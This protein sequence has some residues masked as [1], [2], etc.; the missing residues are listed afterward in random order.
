VPYQFHR[1]SYNDKED[2]LQSS[3]KV[4]NV[5]STKMTTWVILGKKQ[6]QSNKDTT[7]KLTTMPDTAIPLVGTRVPAMLGVCSEGEEREQERGG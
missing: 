7:R 4:K 3:A 1:F 5:I 6:C 2:I